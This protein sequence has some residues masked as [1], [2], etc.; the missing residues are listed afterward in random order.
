MS[1]RGLGV[2]S[3][4]REVSERALGEGEWDGWR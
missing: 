4:C 3:R 2:Y 1:E